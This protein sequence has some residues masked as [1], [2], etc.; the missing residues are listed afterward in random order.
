M[1]IHGVSVS[2]IL[3]STLIKLAHMAVKADAPTVR[4]FEI[5]IIS[6]VCY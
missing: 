1:L 6:F 2:Q 5:E 3:I 4:H